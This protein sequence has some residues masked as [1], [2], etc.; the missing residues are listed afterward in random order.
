MR[1][2]VALAML[3]TLGGADSCQHDSEVGSFDDAGLLD[4]GEMFSEA[5]PLD[6]GPGP[7]PCAGAAA[8]TVCRPASG[9]CDI[10]EVC[11][12]TSA[13]CPVD[14]VAAAGTVCPGGTCNGVGTCEPGPDDAG[15]L[16]GGPAPDAGPIDAGPGADAGSGDAGPSDAGV[17]DAGT[18]PCAGMPA[19]TIC[20]ASS[21]GCDVAEVCNGVSPSCPADGLSSSGTICRAAASECDIAETC[22]GSSRFCPA[23]ALAPAGTPCG[24]GMMCS[25]AGSCI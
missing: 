22:T 11:S 13:A 19:G 12:G 2:L 18:G 14:S 5:G 10:A 6:A 7:G 9:P 1:T 17:L 4:G 23:D 16:D 21:G 20:R 8:G 3:V 24:S 25:G 15:V